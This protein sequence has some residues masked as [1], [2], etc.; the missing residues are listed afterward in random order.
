VGGEPADLILGRRGLARR[1]QLVAAARQADSTPATA[2]TT[3]AK[4]RELLYAVELDRTLGKAR[5][6]NLY[7]ALAPWGNGVC[8]AHAAAQRFLHKTPAELTPIEAVWLA[9]LLHN[10][11]RELAKMGARRH[12]ECRACGVGRGHKVRPLPRRREL[13]LKSVARWSP[14]ARGVHLRH[15]RVGVPGC[16]GPLSPPVRPT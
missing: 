10:P 6:L 16:A 2:A 13:W 4:L 9:T 11:D 12:G 5:V 1:Q 8:G 3:G 14:P 15:G 7:L